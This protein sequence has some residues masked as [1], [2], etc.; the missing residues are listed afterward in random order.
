MATETPPRPRPMLPE[1]L[2]WAL[3]FSVRTNRGLRGNPSPWGRAAP[4]PGGPLGRPPGLLTDSISQRGS[5]GT[6]KI[7]ALPRTPPPCVARA[8]PPATSIVQRDC[9]GPAWGRSEVGRRWGQTG[10]QGCEKW[11]E[12]L[13][14]LSKV[15]A[16]HPWGPAT[17]DV[18]GEMGEGAVASRG[19][20]RATT[21][22]GSVGDP[23][24][25]ARAPHARRKPRTSI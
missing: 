2:R 15:K 20:G 24:S 13:R 9:R 25:L 8:P 19:G 23:G 11:W 14:A 22:E 3:E 21:P 12:A 16:Q 17:Q 5:L 4:P 7:P 18:G 6:K 10:L 1:G